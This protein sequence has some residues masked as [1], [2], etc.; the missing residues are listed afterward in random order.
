MHVAE[1][2]LNSNVSCEITR[3]SGIPTGDL[4]SPHDQ[5]EARRP[6]SGIVSARPESANLPSNPAKP[7]TT[8][9]I[10]FF[11]PWRCRRENHGASAAELLQ[12]LHTGIDKRPNRCS[13]APPVFLASGSLSLFRG[14]SGR[15]G[16]K[17]PFFLQHT[18]RRDGPSPADS[19]HGHTTSPR[20]HPPP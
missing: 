11:A 12:F 8:D 3:S 19:L 7:S 6:S 10:C 9:E 4:S 15:H 16:L 5:G 13:N 1:A 20:D 18:E 2:R 14:P 17:I